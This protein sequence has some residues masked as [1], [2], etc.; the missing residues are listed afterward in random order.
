MAHRAG[1]QWWPDSA[2]ETAY[3]APEQQARLESDAW[4]GPIR[5]YLAGEDPS[6]ADF[7]DVSDDERAK[8]AE[9]KTLKARV[10]T[11]ISEVATEALGI[12]TGHVNREAQRRIASCLRQL[13]WE[14]RH[15]G[16]ERWWEPSAL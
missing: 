10:R 13:R 4:D 11:T 3:A 14:P 1:E 9:R 6:A 7:P 12:S 5:S 2:F 16:N 8:H 15:S